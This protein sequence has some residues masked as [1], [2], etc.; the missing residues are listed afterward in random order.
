MDT[1]FW[2]I[3]IAWLKE[4]SN[5]THKVMCTIMVQLSIKQTTRKRHFYSQCKTEC[6]VPSFLTYESLF[7]YCV[8]WRVAVT[9]CRVAMWLHPGCYKKATPAPTLERT[10]Q[11]RDWV[12]LH[13]V[14]LSVCACTSR[15]GGLLLRCAS[16][17]FKTC[18][19]SKSSNL[20]VPL[21]TALAWGSWVWDISG[22]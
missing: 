22:N 1:G 17:E 9:L 3:K 19:S 11:C 2:T 10:K 16:Q 14:A 5:F 20:L 4:Y 18:S 8:L 15:W 12:V 6:T 13:L 7:Y 21:L